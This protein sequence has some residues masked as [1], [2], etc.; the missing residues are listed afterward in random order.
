MKMTKI[1]IEVVGNDDVDAL[2][3]LHRGIGMLLNSHLHGGLHH[4]SKTGISNWNG[5]VECSVE[6]IETGSN[7]EN[8][9]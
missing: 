1:S 9:L 3:L 6:K 7:E 2:T 8:H 5:S 4:M